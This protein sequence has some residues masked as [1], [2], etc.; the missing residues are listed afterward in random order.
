MSAFLCPARQE[1]GLL[2]D[3][4][5]NVSFVPSFPFSPSLTNGVEPV[6]NTAATL[7]NRAPFVDLDSR[8]SK[9]SS[10]ACHSS[11]PPTSLEL[12]TVDRSVEEPAQQ[13]RVSHMSHSQLSVIS[14]LAVCRG[15]D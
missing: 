7:S 1:V 12:P 9:R 15:Q 14:L 8:V 10:R 6:V 2:K 13:E 11:R 5:G 3:P 4:L